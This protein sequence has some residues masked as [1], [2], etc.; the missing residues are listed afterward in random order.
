[1]K[2]MFHKNDVLDLKAR[3]EKLSL[4]SVSHWG[5]FTVQQMI[6]H[7][8][9][10]HEFALGHKGISPEVVKGPPMFIRTF[11]RLYVPFPREK[12]KTSPIMLTTSPGDW[13]HDKIH[14]LELMDEFTDSQNREKWVVHPFFGPLNGQDWARLTWRHM[15]YHLTQFGV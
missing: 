12:I 7:L 5:K 8:V 14:L 10:Q 3:V 15:D 6:C 1:M 11:I 2:S 4:N 13:H 9:D